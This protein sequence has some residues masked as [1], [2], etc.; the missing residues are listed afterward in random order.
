MCDGFIKFCHVF[1]ENVISGLISDSFTLIAGFIAI[2]IPLAIQTLEKS[3]SKYNSQ[4]L[5]RYATQ[6]G[7]VTP[8]RITLATVL[9]VLA[10]I[11]MKLFGSYYFTNYQN[12]YCY[13]SI[14]LLA[15]FASIFI[16]VGLWYVRIYRVIGK[17][18]IGLISEL[19]NKR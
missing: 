11:F 6:M 12:V 17:S 14:S 2:G 9:F 7:L 15:F 4:Y 8:G 19:E 1:R 13:L 10:A 18:D 16:I 3:A 5:I